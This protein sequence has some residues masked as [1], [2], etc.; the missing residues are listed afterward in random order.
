MGEAAI[1][2]PE[3]SDEQCQAWVDEFD[4]RLKDH[5]AA[6]QDRTSFTK[7]NIGAIP[8]E[9]VDYVDRQMYERLARRPQRD[10]VPTERKAAGAMIGLTKEGGLF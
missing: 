2:A 9:V 5:L 7:Q 4:A 3:W 1:Q 8:P 6:G 10:E